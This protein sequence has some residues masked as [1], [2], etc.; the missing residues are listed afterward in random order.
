MTTVNL[1]IAEILSDAM[2]WGLRDDGNIE[3]I[4]FGAPDL[5]QYVPDSILAQAHPD[6]PDAL[7]AY[8]RWQAENTDIDFTSAVDANTTLS[9]LD[10]SSITLK[11]CDGDA[12][13]YLVIESL[14]PHALNPP[15]VYVRGMWFST[16]TSV[17]NGK[18]ISIGTYRYTSIQTLYK[19]ELDAQFP[20]WESR[21][22]IAGE[23]G[24]LPAERMRY[25]FSEQI[26]PALNAELP[27]LGLV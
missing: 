5:Q 2:R 10:G 9:L 16:E 13:A 4:L 17:I 22:D 12:R 25:T 3:V 14:T 15:V 27:D 18:Q 20:N 26:A 1:P 6:F 23:L 21:W 19:H 11:N 24:L 8:I 7:R